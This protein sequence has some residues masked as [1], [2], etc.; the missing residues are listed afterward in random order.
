MG[1]SALVA[2]RAGVRERGSR[3]VLLI[4]STSTFW[5]TYFIP[6]YSSARPGVKPDLR[7]NLEAIADAQYQPAR[8][9]QTFLQESITGEIC[10]APVRR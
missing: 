8:I 4:P 3:S 10:V 1:W 6:L 9:N 2:L 5:Q 7:H